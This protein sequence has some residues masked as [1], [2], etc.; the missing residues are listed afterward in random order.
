MKNFYTVE[1]KNQSHVFLKVNVILGEKKKIYVA[2]NF[3]NTYPHELR[4]HNKGFS[5]CLRAVYWYRDRICMYPQDWGI[6]TVQFSSLLKQILLSLFFLWP[7]LFNSSQSDFSPS[8]TSCSKEL[9]RKTKAD[10]GING[11]AKI[12]WKPKLLLVSLFSLN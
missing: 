10:K 2:N 8:A 1:L 11:K 4:P 7:A 6:S 12:M 3:S 9:W 5:W